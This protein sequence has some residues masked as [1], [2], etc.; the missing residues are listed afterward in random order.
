VPLRVRPR[1]GSAILWLTG[2]IKG[3]RIRESSGTSNP[4]AAETVRAAREAELL[5]EAVFGRSPT[6]PFRAAADHYLKAAPRGLSQERAVKRLVAAIGHRPTRDVSQA[7]ADFARARMC[8]ADAKPSTIVRTILTPLSAVLRHAR[9]RRWC[10]MVELDWPRVE[11]APPNPLMPAQAE[12]LIAASAAHAAPIFTFLFCTGARTGEA[13]GLRWSDVDLAAGRCTFWEHRTKAR[14]RRVVQL[15]PRAVAVLAAMPHRDGA[16]FRR[17]DGEPYQRK[18]G[19]GGVIRTAW[20]S[21]CLRA[22]LPSIALPEKQRRRRGP[23]SRA[24]PIHTPHDARASWASWHYVLHRDLL[25]LRDE[26]G[27]ASTAEVETYAHVLPDGLGEAVRAF[28]GLPAAPGT[29]LT[30]AARRRA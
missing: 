17:D 9:K 26:G 27:W 11:E 6:V 25:R 28:W 12:A 30:Q 20:A 21:A 16:V 2:T 8:R 23:L 4:A 3:R 19:G 18:P 1:K 13:I 5:E 7:D 22:G 29:R 15:V 24:R 10:E 14:K